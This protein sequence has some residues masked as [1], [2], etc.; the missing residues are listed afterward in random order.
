MTAHDSQDVRHVSAPAGGQGAARVGQVEHG[1]DHPVLLDDGEGS[2]EVWSEVLG[3]WNPYFNG[4]P[5]RAML[6]R[7][8]DKWTVLILGALMDGPRRFG[9]LH[10][11]IEGVSRKMLTQTLRALERD[12]L[13]NRRVY[14]EVPVRV[15]YS[16]TEAGRSLAAVVSFL[17]QWA[18]THMPAVIESREEFDRSALASDGS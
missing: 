7:I 1:F 10:R 14:P 6:D 3:D 11:T 9:W 4:C 18:S 5:T 8:G 2:P 12:G 13:V 15:E 17:T 16:L